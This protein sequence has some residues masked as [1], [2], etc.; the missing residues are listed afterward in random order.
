M[1]RFSQF[2]LN[3]S[4]GFSHNSPNMVRRRV[5]T[6]RKSSILLFSFLISTVSLG[7]SEGIISP[8]FPAHVERSRNQVTLSVVES[9]WLGDEFAAV[10]EFRFAANRV[11]DVKQIELA[12]NGI[13]SDIARGKFEDYAHWNLRQGTWVLSVDLGQIKFG[14]RSFASRAKHIQKRKRPVVLWFAGA[15][16][17]SGAQAYFVSRPKGSGIAELSWASERPSHWVLTRTISFFFKSNIPGVAAECKMDKA[18]YRPC[19]S[20]VTYKSL[21]NGW[22][23]FWVRP[24]GSDG[25]PG[26]ALIHDFYVYYVP[27]PAHIVR[28]NPAESPTL[29]DSMEITF[30]RTWTLGFGTVTQCRLDEGKFETCQSPMRYEGLRNGPHRFEVR[31]ALKLLGSLWTSRS[32]SYNWEVSRKPLVVEWVSTPADLSNGTSSQFEFKASNTSAKFYCS[33]DAASAV[34]CSSPYILE[35]ISEASHSLEVSARDASGSVSAAIQH[36]WQIDRTAPVVELTSILPPEKLTRSNSMA[37]AFSVSEPAQL[38]CTFN[39]EALASCG[40][41]VV[42]NSIPEGINRL[43]WVAIDPAGN[44]SETLQYEWE[45]DYT[46]PAALVSLLSP[47]NF[48][49]NQTNARFAI[50]ANQSATYECHLDGALLSSCF[51]GMEVSNLGDGDHVLVVVATDAAGN[52]SEKAQANWQVDLQ[53]PVLQNLIAFP[54]DK[55]TMSTSLSLSFEFSE[56][57]Q[58]SCEVDRGGSAICTSPFLVNGLAQGSHI[59]ELRATDAAGNASQLATYS[60]EV[61]GAAVA[62]IDNV[63]PAAALS[64]QPERRFEFSSANSKRFEC[65]LDSGAFVECQTPAIYRALS[66]GAHYFQVRGINSANVPGPVASHSWVVDTQSPKLSWG[67]VSP[68]ELVTESKQLSLSFSSS[69]SAV[70]ACSLDAMA[71][72]E[73]TSPVSWQGLSEG[74]HQVVVTATDNAGNVSSPL[75]YQWEITSSAVVTLGVIVPAAPVT[76]SASLSVEFASSTARSFECALDGAGF[77]ACSSPLVLSALG[78]G[79]HRVQ[80]RG[81]SAAGT[82]GPVVSYEWTVKTIAPVVQIQTATPGDSLTSQTTLTLNFS[83]AGA[84]SFTC[85]LDGGDVQACQSPATWTGLADGDHTVVITAADSAGNT[86]AP[87]S[88]GWRVQGAPLV[89]ASVSVQQIQK[90]SVVFRWSTNF[91]AQ[92][93]VEYWTSTFAGTSNL[94]ATATTAQSLTLTG[95]LPGTVYRAR[96]VAM[97]SDGRSAISAPVSFTTLR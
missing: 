61:V 6:M 79:L 97:D 10:A 58:V 4:M 48:P 68:S 24:L 59:I 43:E 80:I 92:G 7:A 89:V 42:L 78:D 32:D 77:S 25:K 31:L 13:R 76:N 27:P 64:N 12:L 86:S 8:V 41:P 35:N 15:S 96:V 47:V 17:I 93:R 85:Q 39:G 90:T 14:G 9:K 34:E 5:E 51:D 40:S 55:I 74:K 19:D 82:S 60:W 28:T 1:L 95:L 84:T 63:T 94:V 75:A 46:A 88:Y 50:S 38:K 2:P 54:Q 71:A 30:E 56:N 91:P 81:L 23:R 49:S 3:S 37:V 66:D 53:P 52:V 22:H 65:A 70:F 67:T 20:G 11:F 87:V 45:V 29:S 73:C 83:A 69:E 21:V 16:G 33:L 26:R 62:Q 36:H 72:A 44:A 57:S 18:D